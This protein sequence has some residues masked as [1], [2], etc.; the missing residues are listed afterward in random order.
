MNKLIA[1]MSAAVFAVAPVSV[2]ANEAHER[3]WDTLGEVGV[4]L[5]ANTKEYCMD[6]YA[7]VY[8]SMKRL[9][10]V[11]QK[12]DRNFSGRLVALTEY[13]RDTIRHEAH[14]VIQDCIKTDI[15]DGVLNVMFEGKE[16]FRFVQNS[17]SKEKI[18]WIIKSYKMNGATNA[19]LLLELE[20][21]A[22]ADTVSPDTISNE[23]KRLCAS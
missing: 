21:F 7:G 13:D 3:L 5:V 22:V 14:H 6:D 2:K 15:G 10:V 23:L 19:M 16:L 17:L 20:A 11:C 8:D 1:M 9:L 12:S 4:T 18:T